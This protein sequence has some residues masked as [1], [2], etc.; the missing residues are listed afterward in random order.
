[1]PRLWT[2]A[3][4]NGRSDAADAQRHGLGLLPVRVAPVPT[5]STRPMSLALFSEARQ[6]AITPDGAEIPSA[7]LRLAVELVT[8][9]D[10]AKIP[11][12]QFELVMQLVMLP[13]L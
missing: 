10:G 9:P 6:N 13:L 7:P 8:L 12:L 2:S 4:V 3:T 11:W 1:M 5:I